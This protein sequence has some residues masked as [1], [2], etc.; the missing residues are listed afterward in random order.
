MIDWLQEKQNHH[1]HIR[2]FVLSFSRTSAFSRFLSRE[3]KRYT[4]NDPLTFANKVRILPYFKWTKFE[5]SSIFS[6]YSF[7]FFSKL[8]TFS[9]YCEF[10]N[11]VRY[12]AIFTFLQTRK[13]KNCFIYW[14]CLIYLMIK[15]N[16]TSRNE[17]RCI[18]VYH[19]F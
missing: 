15:N 8:S 7:L 14:Y 16:F 9:I 12:F 19:F 11:I 10:K 1:H 13:M 5:S 6:T 3:E 4:L 18:I 2:V 17:H